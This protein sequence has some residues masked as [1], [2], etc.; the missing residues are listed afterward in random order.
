MKDLHLDVY[1][2]KGGELIVRQGDALPLKEPTK[3]DF[4]GELPS[5]SRYL[6]IH[7]WSGA[8]TDRDTNENFVH[9]EKAII[10]VN[11]Q[12]RSIKL[13][14]DCK[15][16]YSHTIIGQLAL[17]DE[18][19]QFNINPE[20]KTQTREELVKLLRFNKRFFADKGKHAEILAA[21]Q[22]F[23]V[24]TT[25]GLKV[26]TDNRGNKDLGYQSK[27]TTELPDA[28]FL[29]I[30]IFKGYAPVK[31]M[32]EI[33]LDVSAAEARFWLESPELAEVVETQAKA[34]IEDELKLIGDKYV[35]VF[36]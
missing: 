7:G 15:S 34:L 28:F 33:C 21:Y 19:K 23:N 18:I 35:V 20:G 26:E 22:K 24:T 1:P 31:F 4:T 9:P 2:T 10:T 13:V 14:T 17:S 25:G 8:L 12:A 27:V 3:V 36:Q 32:V 16:A 11:R 6:A 5:V 29:E 30:P